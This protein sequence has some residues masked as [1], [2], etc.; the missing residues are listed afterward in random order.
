MDNLNESQSKQTNPS[1]NIHQQRSVK[2]KKNTIRI[3]RQ[4]TVKTHY[5]IAWG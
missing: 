1:T 2:I 5:K 4:Y 3:F